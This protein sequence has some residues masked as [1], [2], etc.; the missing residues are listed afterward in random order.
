MGNNINNLYFIIDFDNTLVKGESLELLADIVLKQDRNRKKIFAQIKAI[1]QAGMEG[2]ITFDQSLK[3]RLALFC[4]HQ[5]HI[6][7]L[8][9]YLK[10]SVT[11]SVLE[12]RKFFS[13]YADRTFIISGGFREFIYPV[14]K[15]LNIAD[16]HILANELVHKKDKVIGYDKTNP[17]AQ[18]GGKVTAL[19]SLRLPG[20]IIAIGDG[21][22]DY[23][24]KKSGGAD[25]FIAFTELIQRDVVIENA[26]LIAHSFHDVMRYINGLE[27]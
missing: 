15:I 23:E 22:T 11:Q 27:F 10:K 21:Y 13:I 9:D 12:N 7:K 8:T 5:N 24:L 14:A 1:T 17:L 2:K 20:K 19:Q 25:K 3:A 16:N 26:D 4:P 18:K 6:E